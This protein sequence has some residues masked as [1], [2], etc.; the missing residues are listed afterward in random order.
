MDKD[1]FRQDLGGM[2]E[3]YQAVAERLG[4]VPKGGIIEGGN[5]NEQVAAGLG[6]IENELARERRLRSLNK[7]K[8]HKPNKGITE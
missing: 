7:V 2:I 1:R 4:L 8:P 6:E 3:A 5:I